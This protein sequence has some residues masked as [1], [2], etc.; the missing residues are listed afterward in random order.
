MSTRA[1]SISILKNYFPWKVRFSQML[2]ARGMAVHCQGRL[3]PRAPGRAPTHPRREAIKSP[4]KC[5]EACPFITPPVA[6][7]RRDAPVADPSQL[8]SRRNLWS[9]PSTT[10]L[11][12]F[13]SVAASAKEVRHGLWV[14]TS[15]SNAVRC[16]W[17]GLLWTDQTDLSPTLVHKLE[18]GDGEEPKKGRRVLVR[19]GG[20]RG[21]IWETNFN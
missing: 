2:L 18:F 16:N 1:L 21:F 10:R 3:R 6:A 5:T 11:S 19:V 9:R 8:L 14:P 12:S 7:P 15:H 17:V 4:I 20:E 13:K